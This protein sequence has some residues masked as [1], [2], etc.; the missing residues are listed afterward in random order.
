M[1]LKNSF[2]ST[3]PEL[4]LTDEDYHLIASVNMDLAEYVEYLDKIKCVDS[5]AI[6]FIMLQQK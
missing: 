3:I 1:F 6:L 2:N 5:N 4:H